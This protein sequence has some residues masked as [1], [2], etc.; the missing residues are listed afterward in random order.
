MDTI[1][2]PGMQSALNVAG[3][4]I[5]GRTS[6]GCLLS[7]DHDFGSRRW[8]TGV[9]RRLLVLNQ[10]VTTAKRVPGSVHVVL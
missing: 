1:Y 10:A 4:R 3:L 9:L 2:Q 7:L 8:L 5:L 6:L